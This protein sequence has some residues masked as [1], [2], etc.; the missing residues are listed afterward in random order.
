MTT[1]KDLKRLVR[2]RMK[3]TGESYT[4]ARTR[5]LEKPSKREMRYAE[6]AGT[7]DATIEAKTGRSWANWIQLLDQ[8]NAHEWRHREIAT[9]V[10]DSGGVSGWWSQTVAVGYE[11][12]KGK[13]VIG[14]RYDGA[15]EASKSR[16]FP[17][18]VA[19][20]Y[21]Q[22]SDK[23]ARAKWLPGVDLTVRTAQKDR[24]MRITW[25]DATSVQLF[26]EAKGKAKTTVHVAH[27]KLA[28]KSAVE[29]SK[30]FWTERFAALAALLG[31]PEGIGRRGRGR[32]AMLKR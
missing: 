4:A 27:G 32:G 23:R 16:T 5:L 20:L 26:F 7:S 2:G 25:P 24:S 19:R 21:R 15:F 31:A 12:I 10:Y 30:A 29:R 14:Q 9:F 1:Q 22:F 28:D 13:R 3:K 11:R 8:A 6:L 17:V 18:P